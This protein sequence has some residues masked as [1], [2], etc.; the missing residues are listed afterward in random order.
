MIATLDN[1]DA[2]D[3]TFEVIEDDKA[4]REAWRTGFSAL[5]PDPR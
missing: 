5:K 3:R 1:P 4:P 2:L